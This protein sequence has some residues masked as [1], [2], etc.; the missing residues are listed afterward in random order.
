MKKIIGIILA[1]AMVLSF[2]ACGEAKELPV[3]S[4]GLDKNGKFELKALD[5]VTL[6][7][8]DGVKFENEDFWTVSDEVIES[9]LSEIA[10][11]HSV[12]EQVTDRAVE[13]GDIVNINYAG[14]IDGVEIENGV[15]ENQEVTAGGKDFIDDF[16]DQIIGHTPG[17]EFDIEV[18]FPDPYPNN[19]DIAGKDAV[20]TI[21][22]NHII[23]TRAPEFT[24]EL[25][26]E[27]YADIKLTSVDAMREHIRSSYL[28]A[29]Q[30]S[31]VDTY[32][33]DNSEISEIPQAVK[34]YEIET[35][36]Q[37]YI[38]SAKSYGVEVETLLGY[39]GVSSLDEM[40]ENSGEYIDE[41]SK[42]AL[43]YQAAAEA[44]GLTVKNK[45][46]ADY[47]EKTFGSRN[48]ET[49]TAVYGLPYLKMVVL[50]EMVN[51]HIIENAVKPE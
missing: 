34:D 19:P 1:L 13:N 51:S 8:C 15:A 28:S 7:E 36:K 40:I 49:Y 18:T 27:N 45:D 30:S 26:K 32:L 17:E 25:I 6:P 39:Y 22:I 11:Q 38:D 21:K 47:F 14:K 48:Y 3:Y 42:D 35:V 16:L 24:D 43:I 31:L 50:R 23:E 10:S 41:M 33:F 12:K 4:K 46:V 9:A 5:Y 37:N 29:Q 20:F 44:L 2:A